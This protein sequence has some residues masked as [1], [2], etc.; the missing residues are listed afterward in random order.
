MPHD[1]RHETQHLQ[2]SETKA[3][4]QA[5]FSA[6]Q[7]SKATTAGESKSFLLATKASC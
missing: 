1:L 7:P 5:P 3:H 2:E 6:V 4:F